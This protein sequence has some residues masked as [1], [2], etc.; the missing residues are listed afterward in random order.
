MKSVAQ[1][2]R[3]VPDIAAAELT[4]CSLDP[5]D[6]LE[7]GQKVKLWQC[8]AG[9]DP[10][11]L[12]VYVVLPIITFLVRTRLEA[13]LFQLGSPESASSARELHHRRQ[14]QALHH[15]IVIS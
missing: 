12:F 4:F 14:R 7:V 2:S 5:P 13:W 10:L 8:V 9:S 1:Y 15:E 6:E 3:L 11:P